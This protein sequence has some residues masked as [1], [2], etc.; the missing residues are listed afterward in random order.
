MRP[1]LRPVAG[2]LAPARARRILSP[3]GAIQGGSPVRLRLLRRS[4]PSR[5]S[6]AAPPRRRPRR[7]R[8]DARPASGSSSSSTSSTATMSTP[9]GR[10]D[11]MVIPLQLQLPGPSGS[12]AP[13]ASRCPRISPAWPAARRR[14]SPRRRRRSRRPRCMPASSPTWSRRRGRARVLRG[15]RRAGAQHRQLGARPAHLP[16]AVRAPR[17][18]ST[19]PATWRCAPASPSPTRRRGS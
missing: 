3:A 8:G 5:R 15:E 19:S 11:R 14:R 18:T 13:A 12:A 9:S 4:A 6:P 2:A 16:R 17:A 1:L 10:H 7:R